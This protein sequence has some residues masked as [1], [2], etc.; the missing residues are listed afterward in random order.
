LFPYSL[1]AFIKDAQKSKMVETPQKAYKILSVKIDGI[2][3]IQKP[4][5]AVK[6]KESDK[7]FL[8]SHLSAI[9]PPKK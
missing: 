8:G 1:V 4:S 3:I 6:N 9:K 5:I 7:S 2:S